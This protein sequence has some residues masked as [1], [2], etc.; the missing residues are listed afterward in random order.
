MPNAYE[1]TTTKK[2]LD[3]AGLTYFSTKLNNY[4]TNDVIEAVIEGT[5]DALNEKADRIRYGS[6][7]HWQSQMSEIPAAGEIIIYTNKDTI[8][9][10]D[11][12]EIP[13]PGIKVGDGMAY[14]ADLP[15]L[16]DEVLESIIARLSSHENNTDIH[17]SLAEKTFWNNKLN[18][19]LSGE[20]LT[21][22]RN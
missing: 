4:P 13:V 3:A 11:E 1:T 21:L 8:L 5:Q 2:F 12:N 6:K 10:E 17:T 14:L 9:D 22:N 18:L 16:G 7:E 19:Q 15:F 20:T